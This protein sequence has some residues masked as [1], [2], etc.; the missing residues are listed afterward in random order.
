MRAEG[1]RRLRK[2][3]GLQRV[4]RVLS[5]EGLGE[6]DCSTKALRRGQAGARRQIGQCR[7]HCLLVHTSLGLPATALAP[8]RHL[9]F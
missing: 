4:R 1:T 7:P 5:E 3:R 8:T 9:T 2:R 6:L